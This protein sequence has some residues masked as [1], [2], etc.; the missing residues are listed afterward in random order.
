MSIVWLYGPESDQEQMFTCPV[1]AI[2]PWVHELLAMW[3][4]CRSMR[5]LP[6][7]GGYADQPYIVRRTF[8]I[9]EAEMAQVERR[10]QGAASSALVSTMVAGLLGG[11][12]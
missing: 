2:P 12:R 5:T 8:P 3:H 11:R 1:S 9:F 6:R 7:A 10:Q 4:A